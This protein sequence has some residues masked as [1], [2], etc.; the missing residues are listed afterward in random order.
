VSDLTAAPSLAPVAAAV[1]VTAALPTRRSVSDL[2]RAVPYRAKVVLALG[3]VYL[4]WGS[5]FLAN[6]VAVSSI[7]P[8]LMLATRFLIAGS[9]LYVVATL[10]VRRRSG[11]RAPTLRQWRTPS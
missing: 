8:F 10:Q 11:Y 6:G 3:T 4:I 9:L 1:P 2:L 7:P 5:T